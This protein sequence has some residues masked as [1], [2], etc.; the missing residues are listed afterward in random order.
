MICQEELTLLAQLEQCGLREL[1][2]NS[3][4]RELCLC[5]VG[6]PVGDVGPVVARLSRTPLPPAA[7]TA[8]RNARSLTCAAM[9]V[10]KRAAM[11]D[12][13]ASTLDGA[14]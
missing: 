6:Y 12:A 2:T 1:E 11:S 7:S 3:G 14:P 4:K 10:S 8:P 9:N 13:L 5:G